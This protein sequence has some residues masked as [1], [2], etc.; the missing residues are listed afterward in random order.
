MKVLICPDKFKGSLTG[1]G[2]CRAIAAAARLLNPEVLIEEVPMADGGEGSLE[3][4]Q[5]QTGGAFVF[6]E[7]HDPLFRII[8][9]CYLRS[10][11]TAF[12]EMARASGLQLLRPDER[13]AMKT[14]TLGTGELMWHA[15]RSGAQDIFLLVGG[16]ATNDAGVGMAAG[17]G[18]RLKDSEGKDVHPAGGQLDR[19]LQV[20]PPEHLFEGVRFHVLCDVD[21]PFYG[22][23]GAAQVFGRQK[24]AG[25]EEIRIL[26]QGLEHMALLFKEQ[27]GKDVQTVPG[28]GA[29]GGI[30]GGAVAMLG[31][32][33]RSGVETLM[34]F[35]RLEEKVR[36]ADLVITG[37]GKMDHQTWGGKVVSGVA[38]LA[39]RAGKPLIAFCGKL[40][41][42]QAALKA[43]G[44]SEAFAVMEGITE[45]EAMTDTGNKLEKLA[46]KAL[47]KYIK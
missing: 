23:D 44:I 43:A 12:I 20:Q 11:T 17:L 25:E 9:T 10:G 33:I 37:E 1:A 22:P 46:L 29:A 5:Q 6:A 2:V 7:V 45:E 28:S 41:L 32:D 26:D 3:V 16:S 39:R 27:F 19:I 14:T 18:F 31:A 15:I 4:I 8:T 13:D 24:G 47:R 36:E 38:G 21:N 40:E 42:D 30:A 35:C 34:Q